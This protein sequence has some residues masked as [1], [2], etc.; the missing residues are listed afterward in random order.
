MV[1][2]LPAAVVGF[3]L[4]NDIDQLFIDPQLIGISFLVT[5]AILLSTRYIPSRP[6][7]H[8]NW[9]GALMIGAWQALAIIP[10]ISRSGATIVAGLWL[11]LRPVDAFEFSLLLSVPAI[12]GATTLKLPD[13]VAQPEALP[14]LVGIL[15]AFSTGWVFI[16]LLR[17][18]T[19]QQRLIWFSPYTLLLGLMLLWW[20]TS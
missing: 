14:A 1:G 7:Y 5:T 15:I 10:G 3:F 12:L 8:L 9:Q 19:K 11:G 2:T 4:N 20:S 6:A 13:I 17:R 16:N 18:I